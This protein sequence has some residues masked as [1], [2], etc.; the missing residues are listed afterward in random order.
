LAELEA[1]LA[2]G[3]LPD[4]NAAERKMPQAMYISGK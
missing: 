1:R 4:S 3:L 2:E